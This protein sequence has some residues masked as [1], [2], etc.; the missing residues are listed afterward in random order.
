MTKLTPK[1]VSITFET[2]ELQA[3]LRPAVRGTGH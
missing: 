3:A 2:G 1:N